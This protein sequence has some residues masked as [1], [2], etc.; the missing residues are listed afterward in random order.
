VADES[1]DALKQ[2][3]EEREQGRKANEQAV[4]D[5]EQIAELEAKQNEQRRKQQAQDGDIVDPDHSEALA[6]HEA[7]KAETYGNPD[8]VT[9]PSAEKPELPPET[10]A[11]TTGVSEEGAQAEQ[12]QKDEKQAK[13]EKKDET[14]A[15][16]PKKAESKYANKAEEKSSKK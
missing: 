5:Q 16:E 8:F 9:D 3:E 11:A 10:S 1:K 14:K 15:D 13:A 2:L 12:R 7:E 4:R 6:Q